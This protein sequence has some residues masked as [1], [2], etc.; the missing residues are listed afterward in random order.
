[1]AIGQEHPEE[2]PATETGEGADAADRNGVAIHFAG[3]DVARYAVVVR[4]PDADW[5][6]AE[7]LIG[8]GD[9]VDE[10]EFETINPDAVRRV[11]SECVHRVECCVV[12]HGPGLFV[13]PER[14]VAEGWMRDPEDR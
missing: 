4:T 13:D 3:G 2:S 6:Y 14:L 8:D 1:M 5:L 12:H 11:R 7:R 9:G 10:E